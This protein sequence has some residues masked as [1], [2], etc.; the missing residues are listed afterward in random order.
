MSEVRP[1]GQ[2]AYEGYRQRCDGRSLVSGEALPA[3][4][5]LPPVIAEAWEAAAEA[6]VSA[7]RGEETEVR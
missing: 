2:V 4:D 5:D 7:G 3:W 6:V 1:L